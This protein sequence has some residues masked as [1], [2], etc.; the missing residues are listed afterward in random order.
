MLSAF[1]VNTG[2]TIRFPTEYLDWS[3]GFEINAQFQLQ[4]WR[5][6]VKLKQ[7]KQWKQQK[8]T[9]TKPA[10]TNWVMFVHLL[11]VFFFIFFF[12]WI[13]WQNRCLDRN[14]QLSKSFQILP[15]FQH[16]STGRSIPKVIYLESSRSVQLR[17]ISW[18][19]QIS[20]KKSCSL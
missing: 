20:C 10:N 5:T 9:K 1:I 3:R 13:R 7:K 2:I 15:F 19:D 14:Y 17:K 18:R 4:H 8:E 6:T 12:L 11:A 16:W